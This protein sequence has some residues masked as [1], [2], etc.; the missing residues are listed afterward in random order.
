MSSHGRLLEPPSRA[1]AFRVG[2]KTPP[3]YNDNQGFCGGA[4]FQ[5]SSAVGGKCGICGDPW[6]ENPRQHEAPGGPFAT[7]TIVK[8][9]TAGQTITATVQLTANHAGSFTFKLCAN[10]NAN[11]DPTQECF[12]RHDF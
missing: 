4:A 11:Q 3:D 8:S 2:F 5:H 6:F 12:D 7:G 9:Y 10:N 1:S